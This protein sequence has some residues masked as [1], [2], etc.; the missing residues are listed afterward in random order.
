VT[1]TIHTGNCR[2]VMA[3]MDAESVD[4]I[5]C[6]P[7]YGLNFMG[8]SWDHGVP[9]VEYWEAALRV[10]KPG[11]YLL[12]FGG[13]RMFH[14]LA[15]A[16]E[17]A[18]WELRDTVPYAHEGVAL[19]PVADCP[20]LL[21]WVYGSGFPKSK[22]LGDGRG[23]ALKPAWEPIIMAR[24]RLI[25]TVADNAEAFG[26]G[27]LNIDRC[28]I[29][30]EPMLPNSGGGGLPRRKTD[31]DRGGGIVTQPHQLGRWPANL[32]HDGSDDVL[33]AFPMAAGQQADASTNSEQRKTQSVYGS[34]KRGRGD[35]P[36]SDSDNEGAVGFKMKPGA[37]RFDSG[38]AARFFYCAKSTAADREDG[39]EGLP[40][41][42]GGMVSNTSGQHITRRDGGE[43]GQRAN[44]HPTVKPTELM[45]YLCRLVTPPGG[46]ILDPFMGSGSTGRGARAEG[47]RFVGIEIDPAY[48]EIARRRITAMH[49]GLSLHPRT[50]SEVVGS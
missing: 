38:S 2:T 46:L 31:E 22:N 10:A 15:C 42:A 18:G 26:T 9:G 7:P 30:G 25:G 17:D 37:R 20:W 1:V 24:K 3:T 13:T 41:R 44:N 29:A 47:Y 32:I 39:C 19:E 21:A 11:A 28:R 43:P 14:R 12:A 6:D 4:S 23:T 48:I 49:P 36:S 40:T 50:E 5:V 27:V 16:I 35:E 34:M 45:R 33:A 8:K